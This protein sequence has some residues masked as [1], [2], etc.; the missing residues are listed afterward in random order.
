MPW[1]IANYSF[2]SIHLLDFSY[3]IPKKGEDQKIRLA[4]LGISHRVPPP[5]PSQN[6]DKSIEFS[7]TTQARHLRCQ[8]QC[9][10]ATR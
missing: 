2:L 10:R 6:R 8:C 4:T 3:Q 9:P 7:W 5:L 1:F